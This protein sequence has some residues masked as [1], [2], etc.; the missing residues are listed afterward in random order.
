MG[1]WWQRD[2]CDIPMGH[3]RGL[4][5][6]VAAGTG[7]TRVWVRVEPELPMGYPCHAL[8]LIANAESVLQIQ[9]LGLDPHP[10]PT[11][12]PLERTK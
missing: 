4:P 2:I 1:R 5:V 6:P 7:L 11:C 10:L 12:E 9:D 3:D 8:V